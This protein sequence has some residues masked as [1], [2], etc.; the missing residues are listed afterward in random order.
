MVI[1]KLQYATLLPIIDQLKLLL[2]GRVEC[3]FF[4]V[5]KKPSR[6][7]Q[8][9]VQTSFVF[10]AFGVYTFYITRSQPVD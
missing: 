9:I 10:L 2:F 7:D 6:L 8:A 3:L 1:G 5:A 4:G